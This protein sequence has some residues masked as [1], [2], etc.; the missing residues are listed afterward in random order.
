LLRKGGRIYIVGLFGGLIE[1]P[2][3][4]CR[5]EPSASSECLLARYRS[6]E[7]FSLLRARAEIKPM[8]IETRPLLAAQQSLN[9]LRLDAFAAASSSRPD[10]SAAKD[11]RFGRMAFARHRKSATMISAT[12]E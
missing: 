6:S 1:I 8:P 2:L 9:D 3:A 11:A 10:R 7:S 5:C 12:T 4:T